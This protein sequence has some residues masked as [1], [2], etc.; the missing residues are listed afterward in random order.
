MS[1]IIEILNARIAE[2]EAEIAACK[3][4]LAAMDPDAITDYKLHSISIGT[5]GGA[6]DLEKTFLKS[7]GSKQTLARIIRDILTRGPATRN[8]LVPKV[9]AIRSGTN[10]QTVSGTLNQMSKAGIVRLKNRRWSL[11]P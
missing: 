4:A 1:T 10:A 7:E 11:K 6:G 2:C 8:E 5:D 3:R 9:Q